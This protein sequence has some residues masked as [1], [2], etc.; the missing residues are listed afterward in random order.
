MATGAAREQLAAEIATAPDD[1]LDEVL[2]FLLFLKSRA[3]R[4]TATASEQS[5]AKD[6]LRPEEDAA[7]ADL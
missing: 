7:W 6:W 1:V 3:S 2:D 4:E 5:L